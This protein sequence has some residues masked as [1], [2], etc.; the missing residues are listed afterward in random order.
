MRVM[1]LLDI[2]FES[3]KEVISFCENLF[4]QNKQIELQWKVNEKWGNQISLETLPLNEFNLQSISKAMVHV[5]LTHRLGSMIN[6]II[7]EQ[8][9]FTDQHEIEHIHEITEWI[10]TGRDPDCKMIRKNKHPVQLLRAVFLM[11]LRNTEMVHFDSIAQFG[12]KVFKQ[13]LVEYVGLAIDEFKR[14]EEH[15]SFI[16]SLR[17]YV[18]K[19]ESIVPLVLVLEGSP[20]HYYDEQGRLF[21]KSE[22]EQ[23]ITKQPLYLIGLPQDEWNLAPLVAMAPQEIIMYVHDAS[24]PKIQTV[25]NVF[26]ERVS[27]K[28]FHDFPFS[29]LLKS[30]QASSSKHKES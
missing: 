23:F 17:E 12:M 8:Y 22:I 15:Q 14:E 30:K 24:D 4:Q 20:F 28:G 16:N 26:Q 5:Y 10:V 25:I 2:F 11:H 3:D 7:K 6:E 29:M 1:V 19:K 9:Y 18:I 27:I 13:D 21:T